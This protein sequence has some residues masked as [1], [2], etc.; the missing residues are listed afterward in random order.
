VVLREFLVQYL[1]ELGV[2]LLVMV[3][4][5]GEAAAVEIQMT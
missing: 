1:V 5:T 3:V 4:V 2:R